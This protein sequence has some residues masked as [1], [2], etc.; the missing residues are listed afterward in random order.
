MNGFLGYN[1]AAMKRILIVDDEEMIVRT[2]KAYLDREGFKT[3]TAYD[4]DAALQAFDEKGPDLIVLDLML[5]KKSGI[6][7]TR[8]IRMKSSVPIIMLTAKAAEADRVVGLE[9]GA[10]DYVV[11]PFS[12]RELVARIR[13]VLRRYEGDRGETERIVVGDIVIDLKTR[14]LKVAERNI[15]L[16]PT[17]FDLL[18]YLARHPGQV[19]TRLQL[20]R[21][22]QGYTYDSFARTIDT[23]VKNLRRK[24]EE[25]PKSPRYILT[26]HGVGYRF[27][28]ES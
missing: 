14:E 26:V 20:L 1:D 3:Y 10:D 17:E 5:P 16:T 25:D 15:E 2:V 23:H 9:L 21:E 4:G 6:E 27:A 22:V 8:A 19:F 18:A 13:A 11:K 7:V 28:R 24:I 12:P